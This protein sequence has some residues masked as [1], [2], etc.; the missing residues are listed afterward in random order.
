ML[1]LQGENDALANLELL[2]PVTAR[3][4]ERATLALFADADHSF[5]A[6]ARSG[7]KDAAVLA[8]ILDA[9]AAWM[10]ARA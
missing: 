1:F 8:Q 7:K 5:H 2:R 9:A 6:P 3:L 10:L 4:G